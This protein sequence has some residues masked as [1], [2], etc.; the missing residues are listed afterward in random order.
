MFL[1]VGTG[2]TFLVSRVIDEIQQS[3]EVHPNQE[4]FAF[5]YCNRNEDE[6]RGV[7]QVLTAFVRQLATIARE[8]NYIEIH[9]KQYYYDNKFSTKLPM[10]KDCKKF[11]LDLMNLYPRTT[12]ISDG[13]DELEGPDRTE[14][15]EVFE[16][17]LTESS[18]PLKI[19]ITSRPEG[20]I[21][22]ILEDRDNIEL[23][24]ATN[25]EDISKFIESS[26]VKHRKWGG[27][28]QVLKDQIIK[29]PNEQSKG[30]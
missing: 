9:L 6:R 10:I 25:N 30:M 23:S 15:V 16:D 11:L 3:L 21:L 28:E 12:I 14:L 2:K 20:D 18:N 5:F 29:T 24:F 8:K 7:L 26:I 17:L 13:L 4:G 27:M 22:E 1:K 19:F